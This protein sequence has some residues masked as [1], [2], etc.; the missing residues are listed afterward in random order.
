MLR[1]Y[2]L[3]NIIL[4][5]LDDNDEELDH[6]NPTGEQEKESSNES[7]ENSKNNTQDNLD[8]NEN[9]E[10]EEDI[11]EDDNTDSSSSVEN[12]PDSIS[13]KLKDI[14]SQIDSDLDSVDITLRKSE[15]YKSFELL[16]ESIDYI[17]NTLNEYLNIIDKN[18][19]YDDILDDLNSVKN[20]VYLYMVNLY[21]KKSYI[22]SK[23]FFTDVFSYLVDLN[24]LIKT[25]KTEE[26]QNNK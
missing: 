1:T 9:Q 24:N 26:I 20:S 11:P 16:Y 25:T 10:S 19:K 23:C 22:E 5:E 14:E 7:D 2:I 12:N 13:S 15:F 17:Y 21:N 4:N 6:I 18:N 3:E 8:D